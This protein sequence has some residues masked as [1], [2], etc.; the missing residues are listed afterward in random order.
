MIGNGKIINFYRV[1]KMYHNIGIQI[2]MILLRM[3]I[4]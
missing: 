2:I 3:Q 4:L 1:Q